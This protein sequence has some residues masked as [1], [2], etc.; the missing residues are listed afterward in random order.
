MV[1]WLM[2]QLIAWLVTHIDETLNAFVDILRDTAFYTPNVT[3]LPQIQAIWQ[4]NIAIVNTAY[5]L[6]IVAA[7]AIAMTHE[8]IQVRYGVK[9]LAPRVIF[10][11][12]AANSSLA[13]TSM[14]FDA[15][16]AL[17]VGL[18]AQPVADPGVLGLVRDQV[19]AALSN[20]AVPVLSVLVAIL[21]VVLVGTLLFQWIV[22]FG[23]LLIVAV[24]APLA[25]AC[26]VVPHL[27]GVAALWWRTLFG[28]LGTQVLQALTLYTGLRVFLD[29]DSNLPARLGMGGGAV[30]NLMVLAVLLW[31]TIK[32]PA[33][34][35][36]HVLRGGGTGG[37]GSYI[38]RVV[39]VQNVLRGIV[40]GR[41]GRRL[42]RGA[43]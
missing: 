31:T 32:I 7:G 29:P 15:A 3:E 24:S 1:D 8:S 36:R 38:L 20:P 11:A 19:H 34:M 12:V 5:V 39:V 13:W 21:V 30:L 37:V 42:A 6:G 16:N 2:G 41:G 35:R 27:E 18:T 22:R 25:L 33:M 17:T 23:V 40:P 14:I 4:Q 26:H 43:R 28:S 10:G 9:E